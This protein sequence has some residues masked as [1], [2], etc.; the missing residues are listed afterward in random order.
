MLAANFIG[1]MK[2]VEKERLKVHDIEDSPLKKHY[3]LIKNYYLK[4]N[5][6]F[7]NTNLGEDIEAENFYLFDKQSDLGK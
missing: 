4:P 6:L 2:I 1:L 5:G 3:V 7:F